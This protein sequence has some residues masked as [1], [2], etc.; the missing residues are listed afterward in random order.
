MT[1]VDAYTFSAKNLQG[2]SVDLS[3]FRG[4]VTLA[5]NVASQCGFTSQYAGLQR[6]Y[7]KYADQGFSVLAFPCNQFGAQE[8]GDSAQIA[9]FCQTNY[10]VTFPVFEKIH[11]NGAQA[12][13]LYQFLVKARRGLLG[14]EAIKWN[15]TKFLIDRSGRVLKRYAPTVKPEAIAVDIEAALAKQAPAL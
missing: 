11:V 8:P 9:Q 4:K 2:E 5:V 10:Q 7:E 3:I 1:M 12:H 14:T 6:L 15:F 13:P